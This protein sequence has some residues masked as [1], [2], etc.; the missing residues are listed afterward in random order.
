MLQPNFFL[1]LPLRKILR[2]ICAAWKKGANEVKT[3]L[4]ARCICT[5]SFVPNNRCIFML[6]RM[7]YQTVNSI[8]EPH[9]KRPVKGYQDW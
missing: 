2:F 5:F 1:W 4:P 7:S 6:A 9:F 8:A 3:F